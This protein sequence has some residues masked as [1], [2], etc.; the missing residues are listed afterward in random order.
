MDMLRSTLVVMALFAAGGAG[1]QEAAPVEDGPGIDFMLRPTEDPNDAFWIGQLQPDEPAL[2]REIGPPLFGP[3]GDEPIGPPLAGPEIPEPEPRARRAAADED[4]PFAPTGIALGTFIIR[5]AIEIGVD[6]TDNPAGT[7]DKE[8]AAGLIV[9]PEIEITRDGPRFDLEAN[10]AAEAIFYGDEE[11][12]DRDAEARLLARYELTSQTAIEAELGYSYE[13]DRFTDP[14]TPDNAVERPPAH[15][16]DAS[17]GATQ[18]VGRFFVGVDG[19]VERNVYEDVE[20]QGGII[21]SRKEL[22]NTD[23]GVRLRTGYEMSPTFTPFVEAAVGRRDFDQK[24]DDDGFE[25]S[26]RWGELRGGLIIDRGE[27]LS[28]ELSIGYRHEDLDDPVLDDLDGVVAEAALLWSPRRLTEIRFALSTEVQP[29]SL[30]DSSGSILYT[31]E[32]A[33][34]RRVNSRL[35]LET[36]AEI[37]RETF[38][39]TDEEDIT[40][41]GFAGLSYAFNR[42]A[43]LNARYTYE[44]TE[45]DDPGGDTTQNTVSLRLRIQR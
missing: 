23:Y 21:A 15:E 40:F 33:F 16:F 38:E 31:G 45:S 35:R 5:P 6:L 42:T 37:E 32:L 3:D 22:N 11:I 25:R 13:L 44:R 26:S 9:A 7:A 17:L 43:S 1:A 36:G 4:D 18:R 41:T 2:A 10:A 28:G 8:S 20:L 39:G 24:V 30:A 14:N 34:A 27:K 19:E 12:D 29:T